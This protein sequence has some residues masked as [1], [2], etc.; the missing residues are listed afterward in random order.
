MPVERGYL[1][2]DDGSEAITI[3]TQKKKS[4]DVRRRSETIQVALNFKFPRIVVVLKASLIIE[5]GIIRFR[6]AKTA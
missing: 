5:C 2:F 6:A 3:K 4:R 1:H